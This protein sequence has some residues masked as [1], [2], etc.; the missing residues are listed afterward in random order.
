MYARKKC[1][2]RTHTHTSHSNIKNIVLHSKV[3]LSSE[4]LSKGLSIILE[5]HC[6]GL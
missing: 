2:I 1:K 5:K 6:D 3:G 4:K